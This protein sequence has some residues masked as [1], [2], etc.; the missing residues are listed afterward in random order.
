MAICEKILFIFS[1]KKYIRFSTFFHR[2]MEHPRDDDVKQFFSYCHGMVKK[3]KNGE[4]KTY[5]FEK[6]ELF[7]DTSVK[8]VLSKNHS[9][10]KFFEIFPP[11]ENLRKKFTHFFSIFTVKPP[12]LKV[13][14]ENRSSSSSDQQRQQNSGN[15]KNSKT[16]INIGS[17]ETV[18]NV[19]TKESGEKTDLSLFGNRRAVSQPSFGQQ[20][21]SGF[22]VLSPMKKYGFLPQQ[23]FDEV[24]SPSKTVNKEPYYGFSPRSQGFYESDSA[25]NNNVERKKAL[26]HDE[27]GCIACKE[28]AVSFEKT[29]QKNSWLPEPFDDAMT[30]Q[31]DAVHSTV[32]ADVEIG[33]N[34][35]KQQISV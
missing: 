32:G 19:R 25:S 9:I 17:N 13:N 30:G 21:F 20:P 16:V 27:C 8:V 29:K 15:Q 11:I 34:P 18:K 14:T 33:R 31:Q 4:R 2:T 12:T 6:E 24:D 26:C 28:H 22:G 5:T 3:L 1:R 10:C 7:N 23:G 35:H